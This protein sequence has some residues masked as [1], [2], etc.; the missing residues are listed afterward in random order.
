MT[1]K[2]KNNTKI[3]LD[4][5]NHKGVKGFPKGHKRIGGRAKG[6]RNHISQSAKEAFQKA[7]DGLG[8]AE[9]LCEWAKTNQTDFYKLYSKLIPVDVTSGEE[10]IIPQIYLPKK[11]D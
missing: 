2:K 9:A 4:G 6:S 1:E 5:I 8:G 3:V 7:F 10:K 11:D